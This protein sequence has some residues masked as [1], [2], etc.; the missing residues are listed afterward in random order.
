M[1]KI[2]LGLMLLSPVSFA[3]NL[4]F[5][6]ADYFRISGFGESVDGY[7]LSAKTTN[8]DRKSTRLHSSH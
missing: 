2:V 1:K 4:S 3:D 6:G 8:T 5:V 7:R